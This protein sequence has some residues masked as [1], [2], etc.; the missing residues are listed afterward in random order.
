ME[1]SARP[2][3]I[4]GITINQLD[5]LSAPLRLADLC[6]GVNLIH[7]PNAAGKS[8]TA[9]MLQVLL[10][11]ELRSGATSISGELDVGGE[12]W[13]I[14][15]TEMGTQFLRDGSPSYPLQV[16]GVTA[17]Q[18]DRY[19]LTLQH[20]LQ[21]N[22]RDFVKAI[23]RESAGGYD[24]ASARSSSNLGLAEPKLRPT[25]KAYDAARSRTR[26]LQNE[27]A[28]LQRREGELAHL[29]VQQTAAIRAGERIRVLQDAIAYADRVQSLLEAEAVLD[30]F[31]PLLGQM[32]GN[33]F[34]DV[35]RLQDELEKL[36]QRLAEEERVV[37]TAESNFAAAGLG[38]ELPSETLIP[39]LRQRLN[40]LLA[41]TTA[42]QPA[43]TE[44]SRS[45]TI[46]IDRR[47]QIGDLLDDN[48]ARAIDHRQL[49]VLSELVRDSELASS[50]LLNLNEL[51]QW[52][53]TTD[54]QS[55]LEDL[56]DGIRLL[57]A[58]I[59][60]AGD[61]DRVKLE[62][63][64]QLAL[65]AAAAVIV[66]L[67]ILLALRIEPIYGA[68]GLLAL[69]FVIFALRQPEPATADQARRIEQRYS[70]LG[71][72]PPVRW[73]E[74]AL[75]DRF[76]DLHRQLSAAQLARERALK[77]SSL[78][79]DRQRAYQD[80]IEL[81]ARRDAL[82]HE[83]GIPVPLDA[84][85]LRALV[86]AI[87]S[88][89][90]AMDRLTITRAE[91]EKLRAE[92]A[93]TL[94]LIND[95]L[96]RFGDPPVDDG[97]GAEA[98][99]EDLAKRLSQ[100]REALR[101]QEHARRQIE[102]Q[103]RPDRDRTLAEIE[104]IY[105]GVQLDP[106]D[107]LSLQRL[108][109][110][111]PAF[112]T[113]FIEVTNQKTRLAEAKTRIDHVPQLAFE[114]RGNLVAELGEV[115]LLANQRDELQA[116]ITSI[117][118]EVRQ[119]KTA[120]RLEQALE[121]EEQALDVMRGAR[122]KDYEQAAGWLLGDFIHRRTR[123]IDR[124][125]VFT[126][127]N[128]YFV[129]FTSGEF[130]L[131]I[132]HVGEDEF[133]AIHT[134]TGRTRSL[135]QLSSGT[136]VQLL[137]AVRLAF[138]ETFEQGVRLPLILDETLGNSDDVRA[139]AIIDAT[140]DISRNGRQILYFTAQPDEVA[141]WTDRLDRL[142]GVCPSTV[143]D[144]TKTA[145]GA[146]AAEPFNVDRRLFDVV[147]LPPGTDHES[148]GA[149]LNVAPLDPWEAIPESVDLWYFITEVPTLLDLRQLQITTYGQYREMG[150]RLAPRIEG[151]E[152]LNWRVHQL[153]RVM[154]AAVEAWRE[155]R[156]PTLTVGV[157]D[158]SGAVT[159]S[160]RDRVLS[161]A[162]AHAWD[163]KRLVTAL[164]AGECRGFRSTKIDDLENYLVDQGYIAET[165]GRPDV[166]IVSV[167][168]LALANEEH[169]VVDDADVRAL[170]ERMMR[171]ERTSSTLS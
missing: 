116:E 38:V 101:Q 106:G 76:D 41:A 85:N 51:Q 167:A 17:A 13:Q 160:T 74:D 142:N 147:T 170:L 115:Q 15:S 134:P 105:A 162:E 93:E 25:S 161:L 92:I 154:N 63:E 157:L 143:I 121:A 87:V 56:Q 128:D 146:P 55:N 130:R 44:V 166:D 26:Q 37:Q 69:P 136:R 163:G 67:G 62:R 131:E 48:E 12:Q 100:A 126:A 10:W 156:A 21:A 79:E 34:E 132:D 107:T 30:Q 138:I 27:N 141:K 42:L 144:L 39:T 129:R 24:L 120:S 110:Q 103:H 158:R 70:Q 108:C 114:D 96:E 155:G 57:A 95:D 73:T 49:A 90:E 149:L 23:Q 65:L 46:A 111:V 9:E 99:I 135:D 94:A 113:A 14:S 109:E 7:G 124:P 19:L 22:N 89:R 77:W 18:R 119:A 84:E 140:I 29:K 5:G 81:E 123:D 28:N 153:A 118:F 59:L 122:E 6:V 32:T 47:R 68:A 148:A 71:L 98:S 91:V 64:S 137:L 11:P 151:F 61:S 20:L 117:E 60:I 72:P 36:D 104:A 152:E 43:E 127:A 4:T 80:R 53:G 171:F 165:T 169:Q 8:R 58:R 125:Q 3:V 40:R 88:W 35:Q 33:E 164:H 66:G 31:D 50:S 168:L 2:L 75:L 150:S 45:T 159:P 145:T 1:S 78:E 83:L 97:I 102:Q 54:A 139:N 52:L 82:Q 133:V 86:D 16:A 112:Q